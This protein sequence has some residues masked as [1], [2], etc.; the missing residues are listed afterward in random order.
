ML[1]IMCVIFLMYNVRYL[2]KGQLFFETILAVLL[3]GVINKENE[4]TGKNVDKGK[5]VISATILILIFL[6]SATML[7]IEIVTFIYLL[8][9]DTLK[10]PTIMCIILT[11]RQIV[12]ISL[13][14]K[15]PTQEEVWSEK[16]KL[17]ESSPR[18]FCGL[19]SAAIHCVYYSYMILTITKLV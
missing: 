16:R 5:A 7:M 1:L 18:T 12:R 10:W 9:M 15:Q 8:D 19:V 6:F 13:S 4:L 14:N 2:F 3:Q 17:L 11:L